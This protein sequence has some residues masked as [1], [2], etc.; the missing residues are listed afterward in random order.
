MRQAGEPKTRLGR[1]RQWALKWFS[2]FAGGS[3]A[4]DS[5]SDRRDSWPM[6]RTIDA[7]WEAVP[8]NYKRTASLGR[9]A[10]LE[11]LE[12]RLRDYDASVVRAQ[13]GEVGAEIARILAER[14]KRRLVVPAGL[15]EALG[16]SL[17]AGFEF[18]VDDGFTPAGVGWVRGRRDRVDRGHRRDGND[19]AAERSGAGKARPDASPGLPPV[20]G[21]GRG[22]GRDSAG[23]DGA[24]G[25]RRRHWRQRLCRGRRRPQTSR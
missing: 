17:P 23:G 18:V 14:G 19:R 21:A 24:A 20:R 5:R 10:I 8:R 6:P 1:S 2:F 25:R 3:A 11:L 7:E 9:E 22:C 12:D 15:P 4:A 13:A 16:E